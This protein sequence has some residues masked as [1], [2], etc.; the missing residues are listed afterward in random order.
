[1][2]GMTTTHVAPRR[3]TVPL[4]VAVL[5]TIEASSLVV[6]SYLHLSGVVGGGGPPYSPSSAGITEAVIAVA[7][8]AGAFTVWRNPARA[9]ATA[10]GTVVFAIAGFVLG[11]SITAGSGVTTDIAYHASVLPLLLVTLGIVLRNYER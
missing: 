1:M 4:V 2:G 3:R 9:R 5:M 10:L 11:L 7:L 6:M 8:L